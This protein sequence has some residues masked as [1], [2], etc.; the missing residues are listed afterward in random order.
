MQKCAIHKN[1]SRRCDDRWKKVFHPVV[2]SILIVTRTAH[3]VPL[4]R[5]LLSSVFKADLPE[6]AIVI[7]LGH[8][9]KSAPLQ[10]FAD[11][12]EKRIHRSVVTYRHFSDAHYISQTGKWWEELPTSRATAT[13]EEALRKAVTQYPNCQII[14]FNLDGYNPRE[15][16]DSKGK[17]I[18]SYTNFEEIFCYETLSFFWQHAGTEASVASR[19][20][21]LKVYGRLLD[22]R[23]AQVTNTSGTHRDYKLRN[24]KQ[25]S[26]GYFPSWRISFLS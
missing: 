22:L 5:D 23:C 20:P 1:S 8:D 10:N 26:K 12:L 13:V 16:F 3:A 11:Q 6:S 17:E 9:A 19:R 15:L 14:A 18:W 24:K 25:N 2:L 7:A 21:R 4:C